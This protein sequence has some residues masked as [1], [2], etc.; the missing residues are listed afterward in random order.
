MLRRSSV[1]QRVCK[2]DP[3]ADYWMRKRLIA[4]AQ[5]GDFRAS[6]IKATVPSK[7]PY[8]YGTEAI[9]ADRVS[10]S[11]L[12]FKSQQKAPHMN[13]GNGTKIASTRP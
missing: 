8:P 7:I 5:V 6:F 1:D 2:N 9:G 3:R 11:N 13:H 10:R 4:T 12:F